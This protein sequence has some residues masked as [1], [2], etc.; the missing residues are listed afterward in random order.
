MKNLLLIDANSLIHRSY[1]ALPPLNAPDGRPTQALYGVASILLKLW[2]EEKPAYAAALFDRPEPTFRKQ[3]YP[4]YKAQRPPAPQQLISQIIEAHELFSRF[5][6]KTFEQPG[7]EADD[8]IA[9]LT[10]KFSGN[11]DLRIIILTG[12]L[13][14]L[15]LVEG[16]SVVVRTLKRGITD[17]IT[18]NRDAVF[19]RYGLEPK[20]LIDYKALVGDPSDNVKGVPGIGPKTASRLLKQFGCLN[21]FYEKPAEAKKFEKKLELFQGQIEQSRKLITLRT[22]VEL[23]IARLGDLKTQPVQSRLAQYFKT[24][25]FETLIKRLENNKI[26]PQENVRRKGSQAKLF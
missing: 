13:D 6:I 21:R 16:D 12:D 5:G 25:G 10:K 23:K 9:T 22:D 7:F 8:L 4:A 1:H 14:T 20:Q 17:T 18:Y 19:Q 26:N 15:Q 11:P 2:R 3:E 24:L